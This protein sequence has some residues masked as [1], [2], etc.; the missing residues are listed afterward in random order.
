MSLNLTLSELPGCSCGKG[1][2]VP[3]EDY[4]QGG[5]VYLKGWFC[6]ACQSFYYFRSGYMNK[7]KITEELESRDKIK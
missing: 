4:T 5:V 2:L 1:K 7:G 6:T 3:I